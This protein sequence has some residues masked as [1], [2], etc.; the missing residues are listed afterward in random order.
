MVPRVIRCDSCDFRRSISFWGSYV[1]DD[2]GQLADIPRKEGWCRGCASPA[3]I[4]DLPALQNPP[5]KAPE[6]AR[7]RELVQGNAKPKT[8]LSRLFEKR[9]SR[10]TS[11]REKHHTHEQVKQEQLSKAVLRKVIQV[12]GG[13]GRCLVCG[14]F[15]VQVFGDSGT[16]RVADS[17]WP[18]FRHPDCGGF[19]Y[20]ESIRSLVHPTLKRKHYSVNGEFLFEELIEPAE[21]IFKG[22]L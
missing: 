16:G 9:R 18:H 4:E 12:R 8:W 13:K 21:E 22:R 20:A 17:K 15:S 11:E 1:Y 2:D 7:F 14:S 3:I 6:V 19:L 10:R 5:D